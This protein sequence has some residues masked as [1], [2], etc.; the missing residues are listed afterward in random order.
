MNNFSVNGED[1]LLKS[2]LRHCLHI[3]CNSSVVAISRLF[4]RTNM[5]N[6]RATH[7]PTFYNSPDCIIN[8]LLK[9]NEKMICVRESR[10]YYCVDVKGEGFYFEKKTHKVQCVFRE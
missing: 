5:K 9:R 10:R 2:E 7:H 8:L 3:A 1:E 4:V 6:M